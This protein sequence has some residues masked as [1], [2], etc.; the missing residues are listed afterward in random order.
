MSQL[1]VVLNVPCEKVTGVLDGPQSASN[2]LK[3]L[4]HEGRLLILYYLVS[5]PKSVTELQNLLS[6]R[7]ASLSQQLSRLRLEGLVN[8]RRSG[9]LVY[10]S[11]DD[12]RATQ[13][14]ELLHDLFCVYNP[15]KE[16]GSLNSP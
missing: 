13:M 4:S 16:N 7:Q 12:E 6:C 14:I 3:A 15:D 10:Y 5:G 2:F 9:Q 8:S 11:L 1:Q